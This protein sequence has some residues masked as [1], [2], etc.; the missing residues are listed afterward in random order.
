MAAMVP[1]S[2][3]FFFLGFW[4]LLLRGLRSLRVG[5]STVN[6]RMNVTLVEW[7]NLFQ[8]VNV[9][10]RR[11]LTALSEVRGV[12]RVINSLRLA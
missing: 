12:V 8:C 2:V 11:D 3:G 4:T 7:V 5:M 6:C 9:Y 1:G 10:E